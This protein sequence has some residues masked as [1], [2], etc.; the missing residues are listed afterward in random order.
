MQRW[1]AF[2]AKIVW[3]K[4]PQSQNHQ[5]TEGFQVGVEENSQIKS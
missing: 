5:M 4:A 2:K 1:R 3:T